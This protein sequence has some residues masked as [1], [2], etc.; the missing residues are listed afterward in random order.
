M[1]NFANQ[2]VAV[3][4]FGIE[5]QDL[6]RFLLKQKAKITVFDQKEK[7]PQKE[8][9]VCQ[10][11]GVDFKLGEDCLTKLQGFKFIFR[12]PGFRRLSPEILQAEKEGAQISSATKLFFELCLGKIIGVTGTKGKGTTATLIYE[13]LQKDRQRV[14]LAGNVGQPML[15]LLPR[16]QKGDW[17]VLELSSFQLQDLTQSP[18]LAVVLFITSEHLD[19]HQDKKEYVEAKANLVRFQKENDLSV[20]NADDLVSSSFAGLTPGKIY[21]FSRRKKV[22]G[23]YVLKKQIFLFKEKLGST[24]QLQLL[25][26]H[27][28]D[29][30]CAATLAAFLAGASK[31]AIKK[32]IFSFKG[33]EHRLEWVRDLK[34]I[35]FYNDSF[36]TT[37]ETTMA[38]IKSFQKPI[39]LIAGGSE[40]GSDYTQLGQEITHSTVKT[41]ILIGQMAGKIKKAVLKA[42]FQGEILFQPAKT[43]PAIV[44]LAFKKA[45]KGGVVLLSPACASF[46]LFLDYKDR[47]QQFKENVQAL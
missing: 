41:L 19:Y 43:M 22:N 39:V 4:G 35:S 32:T 27:N 45:P 30:V 46:D 29:N 21:C 2:K 7:L 25:G 47:G 23:V 13:I 33:L 34:G 14:F 31:E 38:A 42:G 28:W 10:Q 44:E 1:K 16:V 36:S 6:C 9:L 12:S 8:S 40:K 37:P 5:G 3:L 17:V 11:A 26:E 15:G 18:H 20:L 24:E